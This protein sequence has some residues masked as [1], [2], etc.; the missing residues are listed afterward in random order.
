MLETLQRQWA[1]LVAV[2]LLPSQGNGSDVP[3]SRNVLVEFGS[4]DGTWAE[5]MIR[6]SG[7]HFD[8]C[9]VFDADVHA[10]GEVSE[11]AAANGCLFFPNAIWDRRGYANFFADKRIGRSIFGGEGSSLYSRGVYTLR[12]ESRVETVDVADFFR[13]H[14][15]PSDNIT[16]RMDI[17]GAEY[18]V[19]RRLITT[20]LACWINKLDLE[21]HALYNKI[22]FNKLPLDYAFLWFLQGCDPPVNVDMESYYDVDMNVMRYFDHVASPD[23][24]PCKRCSLLRRPIPND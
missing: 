12:N 22:N 9:F 14:L 6:R 13:E 18:R 20:G 16:L 15:R 21:V 10:W 23:V 2:S 24:K 3:P 17:E 4:C 8:R 11:R 5:H 7:V 1:L 19:M